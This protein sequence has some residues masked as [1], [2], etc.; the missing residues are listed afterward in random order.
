MRIHDSNLTGASAAGRP[1][2]TEQSGRS[3]LGAA[4]GG[5]RSDR[6][7]LSD[8]AGSIARAMSAEGGERAAHVRRLAI[9]YQSGRYQ[10]DAAATSRALV[11]EALA[12]A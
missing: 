4:S 11:S 8:Q 5:L 10:P 7:E 2:E 1:Q 6:V 12:P 9:E 3:G